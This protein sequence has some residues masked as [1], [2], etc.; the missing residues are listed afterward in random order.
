MKSL[1][2]I[3]GGLVAI[4]LM[5]A[6]TAYADDADLNFAGHYRKDAKTSIARD[7]NGDILSAEQYETLEALMGALP[8]DQDMR[9]EYPG[10]E[11]IN[12]APKGRVSEE[13]HIV[14]VTAY[15]HA[16]K[17]EVGR[18]GDHD[19]HV[20]LGTAARRNTGRFMTAEI[21]GLPDGGDREALA[22]ARR[23]FLSL[24]PSHSNYR[25][26]FAPFN[27]PVEVCVTGSLYF[28][29]DH[30]PQEVGPTYAKPGSVWEIHPVSAIHP[31]HC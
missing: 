25:A 21:S 1:Q 13:E 15:I 18:T 9:D 6:G 16:I 28:D 2:K 26:R 22:E 5:A 19:F 8:A 7:S 30:Q 14:Q 3:A 17:L 24:L 12:T 29:A 10:I 4:L 23:D 11:S 31:G 20:M 27:P